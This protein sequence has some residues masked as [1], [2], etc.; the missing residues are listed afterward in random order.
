MGIVMPEIV[1]EY[2]IRDGVL[3]RFTG[4]GAAAVIPEGVTAIGPSAFFRKSKLSRVTLPSGLTRIGADAFRECSML[5]EIN[6]PDTV[7]AIGSGAFC[8]CMR[9]AE[10]SIPEGVTEICEWTFAW[11]KRL[12]RLTMPKS[13]LSIGNNAFVHCASLKEIKLPNGLHTLGHYAFGGCSLFTE[14]TLPSTAKRLGR[15]IFNACINLKS[16]TL[17]DTLAEIPDETF[18]E[19]Q[20]LR[21]VK[22]PDSVTRIGRYAFYSCTSLCDPELPSAVERLEECAFGSSSIKTVRLG[23][24]ISYIGAKAVPRSVGY[25]YIPNADCEIHRDAFEKGTAFFIPAVLSRIPKNLLTNAMVGY[26]VAIDRGYIPD[27]SADDGYLHLWREP[28]QDFPHNLEDAYSDLAR[29]IVR[30]LTSKRLITIEKADYLLKHYEND[31]EIL[32]IIVDYK[33]N[34]LGGKNVEDLLL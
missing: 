18:K 4:N 6:I 16:V 20:S 21:D 27:G 22:I 7:T 28:S 29:Q 3:I 34:V 32:S 31:T 25:V 2:E 11:C 23:E 26:T 24:R 33:A 17:P 14:V 8:S 13:V 10:I 30:Y 15:G 5:S 9:L 19:C 1:N 12:T